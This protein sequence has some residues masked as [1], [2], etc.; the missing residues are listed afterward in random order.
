MKVSYKLLFLVCTGIL[1][2]CKPIFAQDFLWERSLNMEVESF[3]SVCMASDGQ[4]LCGGE[5]FA[6]GINTPT[7]GA[8]FGSALVKFSINGD[9]LWIKKMPYLGYIKT[10]CPTNS[11]LI[12][13]VFQVKQANP[14]GGNDAMYFPAVTLLANDSSITIQKAFPEMNTFQLGDSYLTTDGGLILFGTKSPSLIPGYDSDFYAIKIDQVGNLEWSRA[15]NPGTTNSFCQGGQVEPIANGNFLVSGSMGSRIV[16]F[17]ID[18]ETGLDTNFVQWYQTPSNNLINNSGVNQGPDGSKRVSGTRMV[19]PSYF[20]FGNHISA[21]Q[22]TWG[23][24][25]RGGSFPPYINEDGSSI[26]VYGV[27]INSYVS[28]I[29]ADSFVSWKINTATESQIE[30]KKILT[31]LHYDLDGTGYLVGSNTPSWSVTGQ[32]FYIAK[33]SGI[34]YPFDP[35]GIR[36]VHLVKTDAFPF[37]NPTNQSFRFKK[38][39]QKGEVYLFTIEGKRVLSQP[40]LLPDVPINVSGL[41]AGTYLYRAVLDGRPHWGKIV[42]E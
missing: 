30:G 39:F 16:S 24:E 20:Y 1:S 42:K 7:F 35:T 17:E 34:G 5:T 38:E 8:L 27:S 23:G 6:F 14:L 15:I 41:A 40:T 21:S 18:P 22:K 19:S 25:Q 33:F 36:Q 3:H 31:D 32:D 11:G 12:W 2:W 26:L 28:K 9:S 37:P 29:E 10:L 4:I 13:A